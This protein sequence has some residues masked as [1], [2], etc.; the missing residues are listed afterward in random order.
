LNQN[1]YYSKCLYVGKGSNQQY[2]KTYWLSSHY[3]VHWNQAKTL[4]N[5]YGLE[6]VSVDSL[7]ESDHLRE[8]CKENI[9]LFDS[10]T[11]IG[12]LTTVKR[13]KTEWYWV[14][15]GKKLNFVLEFLPGQPD[16]SSNIEMCLSL[17]KSGGKFLYNDFPCYGYHAYKFICQSKSYF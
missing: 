2:E 7:D 13:S 15:S 4:C 8:L 11:H 3:K 10:W 14:E 9:G 12:G 5:S 1:V 16:C 17:G 6:F